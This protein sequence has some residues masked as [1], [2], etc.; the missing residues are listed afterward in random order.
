MQRTRV[1]AD[2]T[3]VVMTYTGPSKTYAE[4]GW[5]APQHWRDDYRLAPGEVLTDHIRTHDDVRAFPQENGVTLELG[6]VL[7][8]LPHE[9]IDAVIKA[10]QK[11]QKQ[12]KAS[13]PAEEAK[14]GA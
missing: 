11:A 8:G 12:S 9:Q 6:G 4:P 7:H 3:R 5:D 14:D 1:E 2:G 13:S 10:L